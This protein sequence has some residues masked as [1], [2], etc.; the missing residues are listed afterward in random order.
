[1]VLI[2]SDTDDLST[3]EVIDWLRFYKIDFLRISR[4]DKIIFNKIVISNT[5]LNVSFF[6]NNKQYSLTDFKAFWYRRGHYNFCKRNRRE[7]IN[8][9]T[10]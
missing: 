5:D 8:Y 2:I 4:N 3:H 10:D 9:Q 7:S 1:M 6:I